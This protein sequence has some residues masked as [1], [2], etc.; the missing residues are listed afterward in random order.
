MKPFSVDSFQIRH[1]RT[2]YP[3]GSSDRTDDELPGG[4]V[5]AVRFLTAVLLL[6]LRRDEGGGELDVA[7][8]KGDLLSLEIGFLV[9]NPP[10]INQKSVA[11]KISQTEIFQTIEKATICIQ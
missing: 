5:L 9:Q 7:L 8:V 1:K 6:P 3:D 4:G 10:E 11:G 2:S